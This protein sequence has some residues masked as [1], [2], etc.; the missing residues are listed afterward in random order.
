MGIL[1][2]PTA[3]ASGRLVRNIRPYTTD[4]SSAARVMYR[5]PAN[6]ASSGWSVPTQTNRDAAS[7]PDYTS[8]AFFGDRCVRIVTGGGGQ[9]VYAL[10]TGAAT[11]FDGSDCFVRVTLKVMNYNF[12]L[13]S[14]IVANASA[15]TVGTASFGFTAGTGGAGSNVIPAGRWVTLDIPQS[16]FS[17][18]P[19]WADLQFF[20]VGV[21]DSG[22]PADVRVHSFDLVKRDSLGTNPNGM[23]V[24]SADDSHPTQHSVLLPALKARGWK[25][26]L[27]PIPGAHGSS[28][29]FLSDAQVL[30]M[31]AEGWD[32]GAHCYDA[33]SHAK[34]LQN[35]TSEQRLAEFRA[36]VA[37]QKSLGLPQ[38]PSHA[39]PLGTHDAASEADVALFWSGS[40]LATSIDNTL[41]ETATPA[42][43][44]SL[45]AINITAGASAIGTAAALA[46]AQKGVLYVMSH[47]F[48]TSGGDANTV[49]PTVLTDVLNAIAASGC[50]VVTMAE[51]LRRGGLN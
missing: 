23:V 33:S 47:S 29:I 10:R 9:H 46:K 41:Y 30:D 48:L 22:G 11:A 50:D 37:W 27:H 13:L 4:Q 44:Y 2:A 43:P 49:T 28:S 45:A 32:I 3:D 14:V 19:N 1:D 51:A 24:I 6:R 18:N 5:N 17:G 15:T 39:W 7:T 26:T 42:R 8:D 20:R 40:R 35:L 16:K 21:T 34:G 25:A 31:A 12:T 36:C 38:S